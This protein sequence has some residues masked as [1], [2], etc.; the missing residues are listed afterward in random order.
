VEQPVQSQASLRCSH[1]S[2]A[3]IAGCSF[4]NIIKNLLIG[5][6]R[7]TATSKVDE[8]RAELKKMVSCCLCASGCASLLLLLLLAARP[9]QLTCAC[10][11]I[12]Q[13]L[14]APPA[15]FKATQNEGVCWLNTAL[16]FEATGKR[17]RGLR[18]ALTALLILQTRRR[19]PSTPRSGGR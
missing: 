19:W 13:K 11:H 5:D 6:G 9:A 1:C 15:W 2:H 7:L 10:V 3:E 18:L 16:T 17:A 4:R 8:M 14:V 12:P